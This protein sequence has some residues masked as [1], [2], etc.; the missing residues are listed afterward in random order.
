MNGVKTKMKIMAR[1]IWSVTLLR[2]L[3]VIFPTAASSL[4]LSPFTYQGQAQPSN[5]YDGTSVSSYR[6]DFTATP[7]AE[8]RRGWNSRTAGTRE[9]FADLHKSIA[10]RSVTTPYDPA[11]QATTAEAQAALRQVQSGA[12]IYRQAWTCFQKTSDAQLWGLQN[13]ATTP[14]YAAQLGMPTAATEGE[15]FWMMGGRVPPGSPVITRPAPP[16]PPNPAGKMEA[17]VNP[18][19]A[20]I[21]W[22]HMP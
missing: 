8:G 2:I 1:L 22:F 13:P 4:A 18:G 3:S 15:Y 12:P 16:I 17:V 10:A 5:A 21:D 20:Q 7:F 9:V 11:V 14:N 19:G 6:Y